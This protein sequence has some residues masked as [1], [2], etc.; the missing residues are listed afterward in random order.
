MVGQSVADRV[1]ALAYGALA[2]LPA[3]RRGQAEAQY[4]NGILPRLREAMT[5]WLRATALDQAAFGSRLFGRSADD[6]VVRDLHSA[7][8]RAATATT[9]DDLR[10]A[11]GKLAR[12]MEA[13]GIDRWPHFVADAQERARDP[14]TQAAIEQSRQPPAPGRDA[15]QP[16]YPLETLL[17]GLGAKRLADA[18][19]ILG[20]AI[21]RQALPERRPR[22][23]GAAKPENVVG[24]TAARTGSAARVEKTSTATEAETQAIPL[25]RSRFGHT[26]EKHGQDATAFLTNRARAMGTPNGQFLDDQAAARFIQE[27]LNKTKGGPV[28]LPIPKNFPVRIINPDGSFSPARTI[29][30]VPGGKGVKTAYPE[31]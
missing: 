13:V 9:H 16:V 31:P 4:N 23:G 1:L 15:I 2:S 19:R 5:A 29:R 10:E 25:S 18:A 22:V 24:E 28:S 14:A 27:N 7:A 11:S 17:P 30:L 8:L 12:A 26:F 6:P 21:L 3:A 20:G